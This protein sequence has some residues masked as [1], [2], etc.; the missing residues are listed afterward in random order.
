MVRQLGR[1]MILMLR[2]ENDKPVY[3]LLTGLTPS[4]ATLRMGGVV[5][6]VSLLS[7]A[8]MWRGDFATFWRAPPGYANRLVDGTSGPAVDWLAAKLAALRGE[9]RP[10]G[11][12]KLDA[13]LKAKVYEF[14][15]SHELT[16]NGQPGPTTFMQLNRAAGVDEPRL[17]S[18][19]S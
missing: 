7:L 4:S 17:S 5:Q 8:T 10:T 18:E 13:A 16:P 11:Q 12:Q 19:T 3:A 15:L 1:P 6:T 9:P 14:Q 2:D